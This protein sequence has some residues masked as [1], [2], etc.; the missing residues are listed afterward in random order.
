[1][2]EELINIET[3]KLAKEKGFDI[4]TAWHYHPKYGL[5]TAFWEEGGKD[6]SNYNSDDWASGYYSAPT[7]SLLQKWIREKHGIHICIKR[8]EGR[9]ESYSLT[10]SLI[11]WQECINK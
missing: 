5:H 1:M 8:M 9:S 11:Y 10:V 6:N 2:K 4:P 7:Q 3:S